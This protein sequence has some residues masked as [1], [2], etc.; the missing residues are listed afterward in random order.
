MIGNL[1][2]RAAGISVFP[3]I[4]F[5]CRRAQIESVRR[6]GKQLHFSGKLRKNTLFLS[7]KRV[8]IVEVKKEPILMFH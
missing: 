6:E 4:R 3:V 8:K 7:L 5:G 1:F 2:L